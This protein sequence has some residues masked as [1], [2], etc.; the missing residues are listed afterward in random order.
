MSLKY[1]E[2]CKS[3]HSKNKLYKNFY[4]HMKDISQTK[5]QLKLKI[6][7]QSSQKSK[8]TSSFSSMS[9]VSTNDMSSQIGS[10]FPNKLF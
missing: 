10:F 4:F 2:L 3:I 8:L 5:H 1:H 6:N 9:S 7:L